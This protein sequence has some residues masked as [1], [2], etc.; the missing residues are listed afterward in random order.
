MF[1][2][3]T[4]ATNTKKN[5]ETFLLSRT[6]NR[7]SSVDN[8][9]THCNRCMLVDVGRAGRLIYFGYARCPV[10]MCWFDQ[11]T[12]RFGFS[13]ALGFTRIHLSAARFQLYLQRSFFFSITR[14][15][16]LFLS[17][18]SSLLGCIFFQVCIN[19]YFSLFFSLR[20][21]PFAGYRVPTIENFS[22]LTLEE[23]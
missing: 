16:D 1:Q 4:Q 17:L 12:V 2:C 23:R 11:F 14:S 19:I 18:C 13:V 8:L 3:V 21:I 9:H 6:Y 20:S 7:H 22:S 5:D 10:P 15:I